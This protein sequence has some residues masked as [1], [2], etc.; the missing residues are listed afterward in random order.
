MVTRKL[1]RSRTY[2]YFGG[3][4]GGIA[5]YLNIPAWLVRVAFVVL[6][7]VPL[8]IPGFRFGVLIMPIVYAVL[9]AKLP[10]GEPRK[11]LDPN[12]ID[13]DFEVKE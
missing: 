5:E 9:M 13:A 2:H 8:F 1:A 6:T 11:K 7:L 12:T 4:C 3:V 10:F